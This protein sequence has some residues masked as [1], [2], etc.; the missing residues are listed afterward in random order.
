VTWNSRL[1]ILALVTAL[2]AA[3]AG[4][5]ARTLLID[6]THPFDESTVYWP[7]AKP[8]KLQS[9]HHGETPGGWW[10]E[11][12]DFSAAEHGGT[13]VD[14][15]CHF[16]AGKSTVDAIPPSR[17][18]GPAA[19]IDVRAQCARDADYRVTVD[20]I[21][22]HEKRYGRLP[23]SCIVLAF[24]GWGARWPDRKRYLGDDRPGETSSLHFPGYSQAAAEFLVRERLVDAVGID[25]ASIDHGPSRDFIAHRVFGAA[26]IPGLENVAALDKL[27]PRG[28][29]VWALPMKIRGGSGGPARIV[30]S[31]PEGGTE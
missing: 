21:L 31:I 3:H 1:S 5:G 22:A 23:D 25:T 27:P 8:F 12:N 24:T 15:P 18:V 29:T 30:A 10:Y 13:H 26:D 16:A 28:A 9:V 19:V 20:D 2:G 11:A 6:L 17:L 14:A 4:T 7:T